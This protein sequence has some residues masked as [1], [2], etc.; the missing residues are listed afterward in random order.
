MLLA[1]HAG[2]RQAGD[3][4]GR[5]GRALVAEGHAARLVVV[6]FFLGDHEA[7]V[8]GRADLDPWT[9]ELV[10]GAFGS[11]WVG[12]WVGCGWVGGEGR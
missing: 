7:V 10:F 11:L 9:G 3:R 8:A 2:G 4:G 12:G 5:G 6:V 1:L